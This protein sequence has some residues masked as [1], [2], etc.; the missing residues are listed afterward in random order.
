MK[1]I[2]GQHIVVIGAARSGVAAA[3]LLEEKGARIFVTDY[4]VIEDSFKKRLKKHLIPFE[5]NGHTQRAEQ[6]DFAVVSPGVPDKTPLVQ[7]YLNS[8]REVY[9]E[10]E[11]ASWFNRGPIVAVTGSNGKTT[12]VNW[13]DYTWEKA[14]KDHLT[15]GNIG[16]AFSEKALDSTPDKDSLLEV[17]S[18]QLDHINTFHPYIS[19]LLNI[20]PDH[21]DRYDNRFEKYA[22]AKFRITENQTA[23]DWVI[24]HQDDPVIRRHVQILRQK[25]KL[26][27]HWPFHQA[28]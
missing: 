12:V 5:E 16:D 1:S 10:I 28:E 7:K 3:E 26:H 25:K 24:Y 11:A 4:N 21:L 14:E 23:D 6:A 22:A 9:S 13:L 18:F 17:S 19:I 20:T 15:A 8:G 27:I 2:E